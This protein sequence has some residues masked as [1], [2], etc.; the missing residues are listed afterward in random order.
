[1][2]KVLLSDFGHYKLSSKAMKFIAKELGKECYFYDY[3]LSRIVDESMLVKGYWYAVTSKDRPEFPDETA[4]TS[5]EEYTDDRSNPLLIKTV[6]T[7]GRDAFETD[8]KHMRIA[9]IPDGVDWEINMNNETGYEWIAEKH[10]KWHGTQVVRQKIKEE[11][12]EY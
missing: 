10:Q 4:P 8:Y 12:W 2:I 6:E 7:L 5:L 11:Q 1:M 9:E 3:D